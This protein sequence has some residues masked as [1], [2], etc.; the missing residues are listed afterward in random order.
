MA[1]GQLVLQL[2]DVGDDLLDALLVELQRLGHVVKDADVVHDQAVRLL[3]AIGAVG[4][5]DGLQQ[6][7]VLHRLV[8]VHRLQ[9][10]RVEA[11]QQLGGDDQEL[12]RVVGVA[13]AVEQ[14]L[15]GVPV[16]AC[17]GW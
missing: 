14:L 4:A 5:A 7:V 12:Q 2:L 6:G 10:R 15:L 11:G 3:V 8:E 13:E 17:R 9:D 16:A 1:S